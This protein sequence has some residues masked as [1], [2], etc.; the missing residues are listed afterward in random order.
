MSATCGPNTAGCLE[1][2]T[3]CVYT[4]DAAA[5]RV[6]EYDGILEAVQVCGADTLVMEHIG[7]DIGIIEARSS[8]DNLPVQL[9]S[10]ATAHMAKLPVFRL[11]CDIAQQARAVARVT[12]SGDTVR[13]WVHVIVETREK[14]IELMRQF[15]TCA[16]AAG[17]TY[18]SDLPFNMYAAVVSDIK[19]LPCSALMRTLAA[20]YSF[21]DSVAS[22]DDGSGFVPSRIW[23]HKQDKPCVA[24]WPR[25]TRRVSTWAGRPV[26]LERTCVQFSCP[27]WYHL[28]AQDF[29]A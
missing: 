26:V 24:R 18:K 29:V 8:V 22:V 23:Q 21:R 25:N 10:C 13:E 14:G 19:H 20:K 17:A 7:A 11:H 1:F 28:R 5:A 6:A 2:S 16:V 15:L 9:W 4:S 12:A 3:M 27:E